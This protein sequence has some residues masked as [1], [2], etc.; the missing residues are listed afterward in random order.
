MLASLC[1]WQIVRLNSLHTV[2]RVAMSRG[3]ILK[4]STWH[5]AVEIGPWTTKQS[6]LVVSVKGESSPGRVVCNSGNSTHLSSDTVI[7]VAAFFFYCSQRTAIQ[8]NVI[9]GMNTCK[10]F[11]E[12][13]PCYQWTDFGGDVRHFGLKQP[14][15]RLQTKLNHKPFTSLLLKRT[16]IHWNFSWNRIVVF[17]IPCPFQRM[18]VITVIINKIKTRVW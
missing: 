5:L 10:G 17:L 13:I 3:P 12:L 15:L 11:R 18:Q 4:V 6:Q 1:W 9:F 8:T 7:V 14:L 2:Y 16:I